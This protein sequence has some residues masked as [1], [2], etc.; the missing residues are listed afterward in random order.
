[1][2]RRRGLERLSR[3]L[4]AMMV[5]GLAAIALVAVKAIAS[6]HT[7][8]TEAARTDLQGLEDATELQ[9]LLYQKGFV[10]EY[11]LTG[12]DRWLH[13][14]ERTTPQF[15]R[16]LERITRDSRTEEAARVAAAIGEEYGRYDATRTRAIEEYRR[17]DRD[18]AVATL[19]T[20]T[21]RSRKLRQLAEEIL[22]IR[23][24]EVMQKMESANAA[25]RQALWALAI[26]VIIAII[27][28]ASVGYLFA[29]RVARPLYELVL[30]AESAG[31][32]ARVEV[33]AEDEIGALSEHVSRLARQIEISSKELSEHRARLHQ[34]EKISALG[35]MATA[36]AHEVLNPLTG[37]KTAMQLLAKL[38]LSQAV[39]ETAA[40]VD[41]EIDR[42]EKIARRL[43]SFARPV[44]PEVR[45]LDVRELFDRVVSATK[46]EADTHEVEVRAEN[47]GEM[48]S[49]DADPD[50]LEQVLVNLTVNACQASAHGETVIMRARREGGWQVIEVKDRGSG[51]SKE[52]AGH[53][54]TPFVTTK[55]GGHGLGLAISQN[56]VVSHGGRVEARSNAPEPG[57]TFS[58]FLP[59]G[60]S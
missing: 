3:F 2:V 9:S 47:N 22:R 49:I 41:Q 36:V 46:H 5:A 38:E 31:G 60:V 13:E 12:D 53:L 51:L 32:S 35:E 58:V 56:I 19:V 20:N 8:A 42:V 48:R 24:A 6:T 23:H 37:V 33:N 30:R 34:A 28:A 59:G 50:L 16:W 45:P 7:A 18:A 54:F 4:S 10:A 52:I 44:R 39:K 43:I 26:A 17:G 1:M 21:E 40:E 27:G 29:R 15:T 57:T 25:F 11:V 14:L 55:R